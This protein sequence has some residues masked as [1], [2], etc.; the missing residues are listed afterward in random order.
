MS[1]KLTAKQRAEMAKIASNFKKEMQKLGL[2]VTI[3]VGDDE[4]VVVTEPPPPK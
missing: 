3:Q 4:P 1:E 2:G